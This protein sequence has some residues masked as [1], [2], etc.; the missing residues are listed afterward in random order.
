MQEA[1]AY[2]P[3][4][5][6]ERQGNLEKERKAILPDLVK[7]VTQ[8]YM[9]LESMPKKGNIIVNPTGKT[10]E[11]ELFRVKKIGPG[12]YEAGTLIPPNAKIGD[13]V[14]IIGPQAD[15]SVDGREYKFGRARDVV[16]IF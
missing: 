16:A 3:T 10:K 4:E 14:F 6:M 1:P 11:P 13:I 2:L 12:H 8:D 9:L 7:K 15:I 5:A